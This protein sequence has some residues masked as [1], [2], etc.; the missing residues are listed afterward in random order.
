VHRDGKVVQLFID[1]PPIEGK[2]APA[3]AAPVPASESDDR[4]G[5][6]LHAARLKQRRTA[7]DGDSSLD[8]DDSPT[9]GGDS[10]GGSTAEMQVWWCK[11]KPVL[12]GPEFCAGNRHPTIC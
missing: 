4:L 11:L 2:A 10:G 5:A 6:V 9:G 7:E 1:I 3:T 12:R 8:N